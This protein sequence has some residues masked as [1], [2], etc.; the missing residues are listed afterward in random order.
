MTFWLYR[1]NDLIRKMRLTAKFMTSQS[2]QQTIA[3]DILSNISMKLGPLIEYNKR[4]IFF[5]NCTGNEVGRMVRHIFLSFKKAYY[6]VKRLKLSFDST[7][8]DIQ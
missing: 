2:V 1:K 3:I 6:E 8:P 7:Q 4:N 5:K